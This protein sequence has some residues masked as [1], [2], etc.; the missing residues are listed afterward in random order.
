[1]FQCI[2]CPAA[3]HLHG[4]RGT[5]SSTECIPA[6]SLLVGGKYIVCP[7][8][9]FFQKLKKYFKKFQI[10]FQLTFN[11]APAT[12]FIKQFMS[13]SVSNASKVKVNIFSQSTD[14]FYKFQFCILT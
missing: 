3:Y 8:M 12:V 7:G 9:Y 1:M 13:I 11:P 14:T 10:K 5:K 6:G 2:R 4:E